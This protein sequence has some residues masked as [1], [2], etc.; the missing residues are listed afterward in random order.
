MQQIISELYPATHQVDLKT[1][2]YHHTESKS[3][4][5]EDGTPEMDDQVHMEQTDSTEAQQPTEIIPTGQT[6]INGC[7]SALGK[8]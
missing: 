1:H 2:R 5:S 4:S 7:N 3:S 6:K 8:K